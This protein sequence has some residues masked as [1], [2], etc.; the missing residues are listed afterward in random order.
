EAGRVLLRLT[1]SCDGCPSSRATVE[2]SVRRAIEEA[3]PEILGID[4]EG[5]ATSARKLSLPQVG[6]SPR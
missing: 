6:G 2:S 3:A 4:V 1:G 5:E